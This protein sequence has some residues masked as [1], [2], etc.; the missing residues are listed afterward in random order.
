VCSR[1]EKHCFSIFAILDNLANLIAFEKPMSLSGAY[2]RVRHFALTAFF[3]AILVGCG[4]QLKGFN[5]RQLPPQL[6]LKTLDP[7]ASLAR[8]LQQTLLRRG[9]EIT[10]NAPLKL[11][12]DAEKLHKRTIA[13]TTIG[14]AA[15]YELSLEVAFSYTHQG[16]E[17]PPATKLVTQR[18]FDFVPGTNLAKA[19]EEETLIREMRQELI[20]RI[21]RQSQ[22]AQLSEVENIHISSESSSQ[23]SLLPTN[24]SPL[25]NDN[26]LP[27]DR[28]LLE[29][30]PVLPQ[31]TKIEQPSVPLSLDSTSSYSNATP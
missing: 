27:N 5:E 31:S 21:L 15:Q 22:K 11:W 12:L 7:Y 9:V 24:N 25:S 10:P 4:W 19:E 16:Y 20:S 3:G 28:T 23:S 17:T 14:A 30:Q 13:V 2:H 29:E 26:S 1:K 18:V 6:A 8:Q